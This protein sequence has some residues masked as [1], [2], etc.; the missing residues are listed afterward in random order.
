MVPAWGAARTGIGQE[1]ARTR[2]GAKKRELSVD[3]PHPGRKMRTPWPALCAFGSLFKNAKTSH[4]CGRSI[5]A[6]S[7]PFG[8]VLGQTFR[9]AR[10]LQFNC[11]QLKSLI[12]AQIERWRQA[13]YMQVER[14]RPFRGP[15]RVADG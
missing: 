14:E 15:S 3:M 1:R 6:A 7:K 5:Q 8:R 2:Q 13:S 10:L 4:S 12:M 11:N 9:L